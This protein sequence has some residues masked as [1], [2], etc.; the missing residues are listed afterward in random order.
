MKTIAE[1]YSPDALA[2]YRREYRETQFMMHV[3]GP[4]DVLLHSDI[5]DDDADYEPRVPF[6]LGTADAT[7]AAINRT[8]QWTQENNPSEFDPFFQATVFHY[9]KPLVAPDAVSKAPEL[10]AEDLAWFKETWGATEWVAYIHGQDECFDRSGDED[11]PLFTEETVRK[12]AA[13][14]VLLDRE[15]TAQGYDAPIPVSVFRFGEP[16]SLELAEV[17]AK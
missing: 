10:S 13:A 15:M 16:F 4:D 9:G 12:F 17:T 2:Y 11:G 1:L 8:Y 6:T 5:N 14:A 3:V 7:A